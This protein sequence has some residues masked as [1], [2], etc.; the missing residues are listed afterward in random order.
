[1]FIQ[2][3]RL[4]EFF[5]TVIDDLFIFNVYQTKPINANYN[6]A[7]GQQ[8]F[9]LCYLCLTGR[10]EGRTGIRYVVVRKK[11]NAP[12]PKN[13]KKASETGTERNRPLYRDSAL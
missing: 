11:Y 5:H 6:G 12:S 9:I 10:G 3:F 7:H 1:M 4:Y 8:S 13:L 2:V